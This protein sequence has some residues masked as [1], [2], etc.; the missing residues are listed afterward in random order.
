MDIHVI[1]TYLLNKVSIHVSG[2]DN[3][4]LRGVTAAT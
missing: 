1:A 2:S 3:L 4:N